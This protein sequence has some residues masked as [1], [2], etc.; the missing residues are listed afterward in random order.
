MESVKRR[1]NPEVLRYSPT[2]ANRA[3]VRRHYAL[4]REEQDI[5]ARCD[6]PN[7]TFFRP[8]LVWAGKPLPLI[9]DHA[10]GNKLD[11]SVKNLRYV[12][13]NCDAQLSTRG[14]AN[15]GRVHQAEDG[16]YVLMSRDGR[17]HYHLI[18]GCG[19]IQV[20]GQAVTMIVTQCKRDE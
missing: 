10:N 3:T 17:R 8:P 14:G 1:S 12:C 2:P 15:R 9:L 19:H 18:V 7:C 20:T 5:P 16:R 11:N 6:M 13:P 4:W